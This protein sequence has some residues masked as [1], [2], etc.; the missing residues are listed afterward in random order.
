MLQNR[1]EPDDSI[2][3]A[4]ENFWEETDGSND[5]TESEELLQLSSDGD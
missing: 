1:T 4:L 3:S 5:P 2:N